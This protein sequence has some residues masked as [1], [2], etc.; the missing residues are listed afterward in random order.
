[1]SSAC[2]PAKLNPDIS[3]V[4]VQRSYYTYRAVGSRYSMTRLHFGVSV[5]LLIDAL[6]RTQA[7]IINHNFS[8]D[9]TALELYNRIERKPSTMK[10]RTIA[11]DRDL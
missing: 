7:S 2:V 10:S 3:N 6:Y 4:K 9:Q 1:M 8:S 11:V 5:G